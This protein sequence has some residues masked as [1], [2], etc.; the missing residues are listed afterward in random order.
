MVAGDW[1][2]LQKPEFLRALQVLSPKEIRLVIEK[3]NLLLKDPFPD[4]HTRCLVRHMGMPLYRLRCGDYR[5]FY[6]LMQPYICLLALRRRDQATDYEE[7]DGSW[8]ERTA[9][10]ASALVAAAEGDVDEEGVDG[11]RSQPVR[12]AA[13]PAASW[14]RWLAPQPP[15]KRPLPEPITPELLGRLRV[16]SE[17]HARLLPLTTQEDLLDCPGVP[18][19]YLLLIDQHMFER[20]LVSVLQQPDYLL[21]DVEDLLRYREGELVGFLLH[22]SP[23]QER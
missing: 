6:R 7:L 15:S 12:A 11:E 16:P 18:D 5:I 9:A 10:S 14:E 2:L 4:G 22:L 20:P 23:E 13:T 21:S 3:L 8:P 1:C 19:E 17:F